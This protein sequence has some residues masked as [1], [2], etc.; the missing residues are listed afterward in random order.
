MRP[1]EVYGPSAEDSKQEHLI[2]HTT[3]NNDI[4]VE[5]FLKRDKPLLVNIAE[6]VLLMNF[7]NLGHIF[8]PF[9]ISSTWIHEWL[10]GTAVILV[11]GGIDKLLIYPDMSRLA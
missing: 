4:R 2:A 7:Q 11:S 6:M 9:Q 5:K 8:Y 10:H 3:C 1:P